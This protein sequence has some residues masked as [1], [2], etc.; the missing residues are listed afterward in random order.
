MEKE[1]ISRKMFSVKEA[2][3]YLGIRPGFLYELTSKRMIP[4]VQVGGRKMLKI[5]D[6]DAFMED[7]TIGSK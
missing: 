3:S 1:K 4:Y 5:V 6:L 7:N 2:A